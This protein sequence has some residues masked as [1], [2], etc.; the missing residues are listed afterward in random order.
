MYLKN[1][2][3]EKE[4]MSTYVS[5]IKVLAVVP[6]ASESSSCWL[7][8]SVYFKSVIIFSLEITATLTK[9]VLHTPC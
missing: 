3:L 6:T 1:L 4:L 8:L 5:A 9:R 2:S 7:H